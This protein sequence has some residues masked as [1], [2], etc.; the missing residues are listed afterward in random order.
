[1]GP[2]TPHSALAPPHPF[3]GAHSAV[4]ESP[5]IRAD[6]P[7]RV[8]AFRVKEPHRRVVSQFESA[9][10]MTLTLDPIGTRLPGPGSWPSTIPG[11]CSGPGF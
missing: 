2:S 5:S 3:V 1:M 6:R 4:S 10:V 9:Q 7:Y 11:S 8:G